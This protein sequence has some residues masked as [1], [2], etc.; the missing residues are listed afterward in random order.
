MNASRIV[1]EMSFLTF[2][3]F[4][5]LGVHIIPKHYYSP[6]ADRSW[7]KANPQVWRGRVE[8]SGMQ[9]D[10]DAQLGWLDDVSAP[11]YHEV[12]GLEFFNSTG[13]KRY[14]PGYGPI[15]SQVLHSAV[16]RFASQTDQGGDGGHFPCSFWLATC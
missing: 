1:K 12:G 16:R 2:R 15:E 8:M 11:Y 4:H 7:L 5:G 9:T 14:G 3:F 13:A 10:L 6:V